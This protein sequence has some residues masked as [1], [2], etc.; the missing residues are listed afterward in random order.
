MLLIR[1][2]S[3]VLA[4]SILSP[5]ACAAKTGVLLAAFGTS[6]PSAQ[7]S[8]DSI[9]KAYRRA[10]PDSPIVWAFTSRKIREKARARGERMGGIAEGLDKLAAAGADA[11]IIQSLHM[12]A[13][14]EFA[15][16]A[17]SALLYVS[18]NPKKFKEVYLGRPLLESNSDARKVAESVLADLRGERAPGEALILMAHGNDTGRSDL[19]LKGAAAILGEVD[20]LAFLAGVE[21]SMP[22]DSLIERLKKLKIRKVW[23]A[24]LMI[25][26][27]DHAVNDMAGAGEDSWASRLRAAGFEV[28][29]NL[30]GLGEIPGITDLFLER[31]A[32]RLDDLTKEPIKQ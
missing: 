23:L 6:L 14:A 7:K 10:F 3:L 26:A 15:G 25:V 16:L 28:R 32:S 30:K 1:L 12:T 21:G 4:F 18:R 17:R 24:P 20:G 11:V 9:E 13:G 8:Y 5:F 27:G 29:T 19:T 31:S 2:L 22:I